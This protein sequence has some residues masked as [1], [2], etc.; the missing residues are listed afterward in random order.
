M[1]EKTES[2]LRHVLEQPT[3]KIASKDM[4]I[5]EKAKAEFESCMNQEKIE[6]AGLK[7][8]K[9]LV[10]TIKKLMS[11]TKPVMPGPQPPQRATGL[12]FKADTE[13]LSNTL[14]YLMKTGVQTLVAFDVGVGV[15]CKDFDIH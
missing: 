8:L 13:A 2:T 1:A 14:T 3:S 7:P 6:K 4:P 11:T 5:F 15:I 12:R 10:K 9:K